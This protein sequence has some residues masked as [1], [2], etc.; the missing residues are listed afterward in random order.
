[1]RKALKLALVAACLSGCAHQA[2]PSIAPEAPL[3][4]QTLG[5]RRLPFA[6]YIT[7]MH[8]QI[9]RRFMLGFLADIDARNDPAYADQ[10]LWTQL[11]IVVNGDGSIARLDVARSSGVR[12]FD[13]AAIESVR[14]AAPFP[15]P[16]ALI[17]S[18]DG[19]VHL[20]WRFYR[21]GVRGCSAIGVDPHILGNVAVRLQ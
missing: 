9:H 8:K 7:A 19:A 20:D 3:Q 17:V 14:S 18:A 1:M 2:A 13:D 5:D 10:T 11:A 16:P 4:P 21:D 15:P 6:H 12:S